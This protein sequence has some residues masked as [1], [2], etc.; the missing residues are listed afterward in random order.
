MLCLVLCDREVEYSCQ[1]SAVSTSCLTNQ[2]C[3]FLARIILL[4][5]PSDVADFAP[6][7]EV[8]TEGQIQLLDF[9]KCVFG[10]YY[11]KSVI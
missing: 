1:Q 4:W 11:E 6:G 2:R 3:C 9:Y 10:K 7:F 8:L 5:K